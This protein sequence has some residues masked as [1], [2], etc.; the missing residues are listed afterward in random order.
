MA[1]RE[2]ESRVL[3]GRANAIARFLHFSFSQPDDRE[4]RQTIRKVNFDRDRRRV[5]AG[6]RT[7]V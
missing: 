2:I 5:H 6:E 4:A 3:Q 1:R 7:T